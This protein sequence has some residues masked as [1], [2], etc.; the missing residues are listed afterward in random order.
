LDLYCDAGLYG[1]LD[2]LDDELRFALIVS[3]V[4]LHPL[5]ERPDT[6]ADT[7]LAGLAVQVN[8]SPHAKCVRCWHHRPDVGTH[9]EHPQ[10][11]GR[12]V[13]NVAG[14]GEVRRFA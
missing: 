8:A 10:L 6:A 5:A 9:A 12:C 13:E 3:Q 7:E 11:C 1:T 14:P 4:R 2:R